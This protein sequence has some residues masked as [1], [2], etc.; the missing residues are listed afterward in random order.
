MREGDVLLRL[1]AL[2]RRWLSIFT[3]MTCWSRTRTVPPRRRPTG[4]TWCH[5]VWRALRP[6]CMNNRH[7]MVH[8]HIEENTTAGGKEM[9]G[10]MLV[11]EYEEIAKPDFYMWKDI[12]FEPDFYMVESMAKPHGLH[13]IEAFMGVEPALERRPR[14]TSH[15][16]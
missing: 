8:D 6:K 9:G 11:V 1:Y 15:S 3:A 16:H 13:N 5:F 7:L 10:S 12:E 4:P 2:T 14:R